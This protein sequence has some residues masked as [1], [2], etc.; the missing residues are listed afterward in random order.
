MVIV[1][2]APIAV[3][4]ASAGT[5]EQASGQFVYSVYKGRSSWLQISDI[6]G[7]PPVRVTPKPAWFE[8]RRDLIPRW[9]PDGTRIAFARTGPSAAVPGIYVI[10]R[11]GTGLRKAVGLPS[12]MNDLYFPGWSPDGAKL[13]F[14]RSQH[15]SAVHPV[16]LHFRVI[17]VETRTSTTI[18]ALWQPTTLTELGEIEWSPDSTRLLYIVDFLDNLGNDP[19]ECRFHRPDSYL[20]SIDSRGT[21]RI[22]LAGD[23]VAQ[24]AWSP[25]GEWIAYD[26]CDD[27]DPGCDLHIVRADGTGEREVAQGV[28][29]GH[30]RWLP[31]GQ[32]VAIA[33]Y[34]GLAIVDIESGA[35]RLLSTWPRYQDAP[36][37]WILGVSERQSIVAIASGWDYD[38]HFNITRAEVSLVSLKD[39]HVRKLL[40][41]PTPVA[42]MWGIHLHM[43]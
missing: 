34:D 35:W 22:F 26:D 38:E 11:D 39:G 32:E 4:A 40:I 15:C 2:V 19:T 14:Q 3:Q 30:I 43:P 28:V 12:S 1:L 18:H 23:S 29:R 9:S 17:D 13:A 20:Y 42:D 33:Y 6:A 10:N 8:Q 16:D 24:A 25:N 21:H 31:N 41:P 27:P 36:E 7:G 5:A 37:S